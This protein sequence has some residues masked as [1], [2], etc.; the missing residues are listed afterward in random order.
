MIMKK[1][2]EPLSKPEILQ[3]D[4]IMT[5]IRYLTK[6][7]N[8]KKRLSSGYCRVRLNNYNNEYLELEV[9]SKVDSDVSFQTIVVDRKTMKTLDEGFFYNIENN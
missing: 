3:L 2:I 4:K 1:Q 9:E 7:G 6:R 8:I 5:S